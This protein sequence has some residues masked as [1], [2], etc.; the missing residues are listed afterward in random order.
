MQ[1]AQAPMIDLTVCNDED[2]SEQAIAERLQ[3]RWH[4]TDDG[5][6]ANRTWIEWE[7][8]TE[9]FTIDFTDRINTLC[10]N[11]RLW[12][13]ECHPPVTMSLSDDQSM[14][15]VDLVLRKIETVTLPELGERHLYHYHVEAHE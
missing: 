1:T 4:R 13:G 15:T 5:S 7:L 9:D 11:P 6:P 14:M 3:W 10:A 8:M 12:D 2:L